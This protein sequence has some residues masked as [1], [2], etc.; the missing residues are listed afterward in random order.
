MWR[1]GNIS[2]SRG[3]C[4]ERCWPA[5]VTP[6]YQKK[7][8]LVS[9]RANY[10]AFLARFPFGSPPSFC[11]SYDSITIFLCTL[12]TMPSHDTATRTQVLVLKQNGFKNDDITAQTGVSSQQIKRHCT[13]AWEQKW[14][15]NK[16][17]LILD[18]Y[19]ER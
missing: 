3:A 8:A 5:Q 9:A 17:G 11:Y 19:V 14:D 18:I 4:R 10:L 15:P 6:L 12:Y 2:T 7:R 16:K 13:A 1:C